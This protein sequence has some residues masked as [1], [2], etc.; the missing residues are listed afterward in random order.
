VLLDDAAV[1]DDGNADTTVIGV[2]V[3]D[4]TNYF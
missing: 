1:D 4:C 3:A 2:S